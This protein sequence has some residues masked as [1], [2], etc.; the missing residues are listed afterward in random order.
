MK[1][2]GSS[3]LKDIFMKYFLLIATLL[4]CAFFA[5]SEPV[6]LRITNMLDIFRGTTILAIVGIGKT[7]VQSTGEFDFSVGATGSFAACL[8]AKIMIEYIPNFYV[9]LLITLVAA[10]LI[11]YINSLLVINVG[12]RAWIATFGMSTALSG[13]AK[14][15]TGGGTY[16]TMS[17]PDGFTTLGQGYVFE[18]V[19]VQVVVLIILAVVAYIFCERTKTGRFMYAVGA[20]PDAAKHVGIDGNKQKRISFLICSLCA[21]FAGVIQGSQLSSVSS[22]IGD[23]NLMPAICTCMLGATFM[24]PGVF[25]IPGTVLGAFLLAVIS[26]GLTMIGASYFV[27]DF[28]Q[29]AVLLISVGFIAIISKRTSSNR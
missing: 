2:T 4:T 25:N 24:R 22:T 12:I 29:G 14:L 1:K 6:F 7:I 28:I 20:N 15:F 27:K 23:A 26:N 10:L 16:Y 11:G 17:W 21:A 5:I 18:I 8:I 3:T 9:A 13:C 19:P